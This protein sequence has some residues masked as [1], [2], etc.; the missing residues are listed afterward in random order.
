MAISIDWGTKVI[1]VPQADLTLVTGTLYELDTESVFRQAVIAL[2]SSEEGMAFDDAILHNTEVTVAGTTYARFIEIINGYSITFTPDAQWTVRF[3]GSNNN[4]FDVENGILNQNQVQ[5]IPANSAG[6]QSFPQQELNNIKYLIETLR[7]HH[8]GLGSVWYWNPDTGNDSQSGESA[9]KAFKTFAAAHAAAGDGTHDVI[10]ALSGVSGQTNTTETIEITK[11][12]LFLRGPGRDFRFKP[13]A[14]TAPTISI[15]AVGVEISGCV[16]DTAATG[17]QS[18]IEVQDGADFFFLDSVWSR[19]AQHAALKVQGS[20][21]YGRVDGCFFAHAADDGIHIDGD[22]RHTRIT[23]TEIDAATANGILIEGTTARNNLIGN[24]VKIYDSGAYGIRINAPAL[25]NFVDS[26]VSLYD[27]GLGNILDNGTDT[28]IEGSASSLAGSGAIPFTYTIYEPDLIT[29]IP[30]VEIW[31]TSDIAGNNVIAGVLVSDAVGQ[32]TFM[33][34]AGT[35]YVWRNL[36][37][38]NF[39]NPDTEVIA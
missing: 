30:G 9:E 18:A 39:S 19:D 24:G 29:P 21:V 27:N 17:G 37:G 34:D 10:V 16:V 1:T 33:L 23:N 36:A 38:W 35:V 7:P 13:T 6:L 14:T 20:V 5:V 26:D 12:Y 4:I 31:V 28:Y 8:T 15:N 32:V 25:R 22:V 11:N 3:T 2:L